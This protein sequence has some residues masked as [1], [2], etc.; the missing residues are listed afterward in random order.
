M[1]LANMRKSLEK[2][3]PE[4]IENSKNQKKVANVKT[5]KLQEFNLEVTEENNKTLNES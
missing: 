1:S 3:E 2:N 4:E 5:A